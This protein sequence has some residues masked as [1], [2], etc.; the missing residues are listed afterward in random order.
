MMKD[1]GFSIAYS[2]LAAMMLA[3]CSSSPDLT[4]SSMNFLQAPISPT[5]ARDALL[6]EEGFSVNAPM[7]KRGGATEIKAMFNGDLPVTSLIRTQPDGTAEVSFFVKLSP[8]ATPLDRREAEFAVR[9]AD[10]AV[11]RKCTEDGKIYGGDVVIDA[12]KSPKQ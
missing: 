12:E 7:G 6:T 2:A 4:V 11:Y 5:C 1:V 10:E 9:R 8:K 3:A